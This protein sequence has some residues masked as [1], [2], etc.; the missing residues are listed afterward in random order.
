MDHVF[1]QVDVLD[2]NHRKITI[3]VKGSQQHPTQ[4]RLVQPFVEILATD[5]NRGN[6]MWS[7]LHNGFNISGRCLMT[8]FFIESIRYNQTGFLAELNRRYREFIA[9]Q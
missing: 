8:D 3:F 4:Q 2:V 5:I 7:L 9:R 1:G 6:G